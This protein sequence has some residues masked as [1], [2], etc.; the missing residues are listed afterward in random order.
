MKQTLIFILLLL[1]LSIHAQKGTVRGTILDGS[2]ADAIIGGS[3]V[4]NELGTGTITDLDGKFELKLEPGSYS[5]TISYI[6]Y[7]N[8][9]VSDVEVKASDVLILADIMMGEGA[10]QIEEVVVKAKAIKTTETALL[11]VK[12]S[13]AV[14]LD[15][16]SAAKMQLIGDGNA[17]DAAKR[18]TG[19]SVEGGK[20]VYV[21]GLGDRYIKTTLNG[22]DI[23]GLD[24][25]KNTL[26]MDIFPTNL[27]DN[28]IVSKNFTA[29]MPADFTGGLVNVET[30]D[31]PEEEVF[32][33]SLGLGYN[34]AMHLN[35]NYLGYN[36]SSTDLLGF[37]N[38]QRALPI[39]GSDKSNIP[40]PITGASNDQVNSFVKSFNSQLGAQRQ[41]SLMD[42]SG[43]LSYANQISLG[44]SENAIDRPKLG[45][46]FSLSYKSDYKYFD[47]VT[48]GEYQRN[49]E[50]DNY[51]L[52]YATR[53]TGQVGQRGV[54][55]GAIGGVAYKFRNSKIRLMLMHLQNGESRAGKFDIINDGEAIGQSGYFATSD[56]LEYNQRG[57]SNIL[58]H[59]THAFPEREWEIDWRIS[60][61][62]SQSSDPDI[63]KT[64][65]TL[66]AVDTFFSAGAGGNPSR[67][68]RS[69]SEVNVTGKVDVTKKYN[70]GDTG[71]KFK[72]GFSQNYKSRDYEILFY[73]IQFFGNQSWAS[74]DPSLVLQ[75]QNIFPSSVNNIYYNSGNT[76]PNPN[77]YSSNVQNTGFYVSNEMTFKGNLKTIIGLRAEN[78]VQRHTGRDQRYAGGD[79]VNGKNFDNEIVLNNFNLFPTANLV[80]KVTDNQNVRVGYARTIARPSFKELS[81]AQI[82]DPI[83]NR[84]FNGSLFEYTQWGGVLVSTSVNNFD[85]RW[86]VFLEDG[87][88]LSVSPFYKTFLNPIELVRIPE[89][90]T[91]TEYQPRNVGDG[92]V[93]GAEIEIRKSLI[94]MSDLLANF[95]FNGNLTIVQSTID[96]TDVEFTARKNFEKDGQEITNRREM[97]GQS[98]YVVNAGL[99]YNNRSNGLNAGMFYNVKG[100]TLFI[101]GGGLFPDI[102]TQPFHS[103]NFSLNKR[104]GKDQKTSLDFQVSN[105]LNSKIQELYQAYNAEPQPFSILSP[106]IAFSV[107]ASYKI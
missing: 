56:N 68:W 7:K 63:R 77:Q 74:N 29:D 16:I 1:G 13:S 36:G 72:F 42:L 106:G 19:V 97:A 20:Y 95:D 5:L 55:I 89:Q 82:I 100:P 78:F 44:K 27:I 66:T 99:S 76:N 54:L 83:T 80:Y 34:P 65:F 64:A 59:G 23:P 15:G 71:G 101:V 70:F 49:K 9:T 81:F 50:S 10:L 57:L 103:L 37:D 18:V 93:L 52:R 102:Y 69:L 94:F 85:L 53:Q 35:D 43:S 41:T 79:I 40:T 31:F 60:P 3:I 88:L 98:P 105:I 92:T 14:M 86:E 25:D 22:V 21:R 51:E 12:K 33:I 90:A 4:V 75:D 73:D 28:I 32:S 47:D 61:T 107:G 30:K 48:Y 67:I 91:S 58:L 24:P 6:G 11:T 39:L 87:G 8:I 46:L 84:I 26:Q 62:I 104:F 17:V 45:Y 2:N 38:G 96:M